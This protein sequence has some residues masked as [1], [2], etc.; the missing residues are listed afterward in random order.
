MPWNT[1]LEEGQV[2]KM[3]FNGF[4]KNSGEAPPEVFVE[5]QRKTEESGSGFMS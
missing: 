4:K 3:R 1:Q 2:L 5:L